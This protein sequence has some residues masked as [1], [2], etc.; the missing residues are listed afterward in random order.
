MPPSVMITKP[1]DP[2]QYCRE[3]GGM[4]TEG[5]RVTTPDHT[6]SKGADLST[7]FWLG[8]GTGSG[9]YR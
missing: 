9:P 6:G 1:R 5:V 2:I 3:G 7:R 4:G 8:D